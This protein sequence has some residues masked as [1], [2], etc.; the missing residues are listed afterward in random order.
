MKRREGALYFVVKMTFTTGR[1]RNLQSD[2]LPANDLHLDDVD[3]GKQGGT[4]E[5]PQNRS[6]STV[7]CGGL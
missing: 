2:Y 3:G 5:A 7:L 4:P 1:K 6:I